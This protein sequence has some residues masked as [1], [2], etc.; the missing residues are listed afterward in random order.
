M[1]LNNNRDR[2]TTPCPSYSLLTLQVLP[3]DVRTST[4]VCVPAPAERRRRHILLLLLYRPPF[5][6]PVIYF[7]L[8]FASYFSFLSPPLSRVFFLLLASCFCLSPR[9]PFCFGQY[10][11]CYIGARA[12]FL[13][14]NTV[15][16]VG[17][18]DK[19][20]IKSHHCKSH[21][22]VSWWG[23]AARVRWRRPAAERRTG[24]GILAPRHD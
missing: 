22:P 7:V 23:C 13:C 6:A 20:T 16:C 1:R 21:S 17:G 9:P 18:R 3:T 12:I 19:R 10:F 4:I 8:L 24:W 5:F 11:P 2:R 14:S 15:T